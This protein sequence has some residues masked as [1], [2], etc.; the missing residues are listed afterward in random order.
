MIT[1]YSPN[2]DEEI[3][4]L[5]VEL[6]Q[7]LSDID[8]ERYNIVGDDY[9]KKYFEKTMK[10]VKKCNGKILLFKD[11]EKIVGLVVGIVNNDEVIRYDFKAPKRGRIT[12]LVVA[13]EYRGKHIGEK[14]LESMRDYLKSIGCEKIMIAVF[15]YNENAIT[16][17]A[18]FNGIRVMNKLEMR[19]FMD[20]N[21]T[22]IIS[23][24]FEDKEI[25]SVWDSEKE[26]SEVTTNCSHLKMLAQD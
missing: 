25:I 20:N 26:D 11:N 6:Q 13:K 14:L 24:L 5:L 21:K 7:Y 17:S 8:K 22:E 15:G 9:R 12:E 3:K 23:N 18:E 1:E 2:Y 4:D 10:E 16:K 19:N